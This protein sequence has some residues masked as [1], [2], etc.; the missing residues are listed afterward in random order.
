MEM[1]RIPAERVAVLLG[2]NGV[3]KRL[4]ERK[5]K[6]K[7]SVD[8]EGAVDITGGPFEE[9]KC[10]E[11]VSAIGRG[12]NPEK[13]LKLLEPE[14]YLKVIDLKDIFNT[15]KQVMRQKGR[16]IGE[17]GR[18][19][20]VIEEIAEVDMCVYG[21]TVALIGELE[22]LSLAESAIE[23]LLGGTPHSGVY[24]TLEKGRRSI[25]EKKMDFWK[26]REDKLI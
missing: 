14:C 10:R 24:R 20:R 25:A 26:H 21:H 9:W 15:E 23:K 2:R 12:F 13:S 19:R 4:I 8:E 11:I 17:K 18:T 6:T 16:L 3:T 5:T 7:L 1:L 22:E